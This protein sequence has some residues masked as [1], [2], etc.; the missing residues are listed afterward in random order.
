MN[1]R[2]ST[3]APVI[4]R[5]GTSHIQPVQKESTIIGKLVSTPNNN[6]ERFGSQTTSVEST[7]DGKQLLRDDSFFIKYQ[8]I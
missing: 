7:P 4:S 5:T 6:F 1:T 3:V 8:I 2:E